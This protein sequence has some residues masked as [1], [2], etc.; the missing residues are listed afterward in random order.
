MS[1]NSISIV[2]KVGKW[3]KR[4]LLGTFGLLV[5]YFLIAL[6][7]TYITV[8]NNDP[9]DADTQTV[10]V[11]TNGV[12]L[13]LIF[14]VAYLDTE[15]QKQLELDSSVRYV[16]FG[17]GEKDFY[18]NT[19]QWKDLTVKTAIR[20]LFLPSETLMHIYRLDHLG[21]D[22]KPI[23]MNKEKQQNLLKYIQDSFQWDAHGNVFKLKGQGYGQNDEF[24]KAEGSYSLFKTCNSW[25]NSALKQS[26][27]KA[28]AWTPFDFGVMQK[29][30]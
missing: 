5:L 23:A 2:K 19:P 11:H 4:L 12:H 9:T 29:Y 21:S 20:A 25:V 6:V 30:E 28:C 3:I 13:D 17:W 10:Y 1:K 22:V 8:N 26:N 14:P 16:S 15:F 27:L 7:L 24:Y 18:L